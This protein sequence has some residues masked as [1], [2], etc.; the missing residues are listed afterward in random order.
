MSYTLRNNTAAVVRDADGAIIGPENET[1]W[2]AYQ[3]WLADGHTA[4]APPVET[5]S[6]PAPISDRQF[7]R[8]LWGEGIITFAECQ[9]FCASGVIPA[10]MQTLIDQLPDDNTGAPTPRKEAIVLVSGATEY[11]CDNPLVA[12]LGAA[13]GWSPAQIATKWREW[14]LL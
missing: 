6:H 2:A 10:A 12:Q 7:A 8:G 9:A 3:V 5:P 4:S 1:E 13:F 11:R 14:R